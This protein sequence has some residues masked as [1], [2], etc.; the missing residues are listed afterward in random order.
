[1]DQ[2]STQ[3][4]FT[5][6]KNFQPEN[7]LKGAA[8]LAR[9]FGCA[10]T[11]IQT[12][13]SY[14]LVQGDSE[15]AK[16]DFKSKFFI[17]LDIIQQEGSL[18]KSISKIAVQN[19]ANMVLVYAPAEKGGLLGG[20]M[21]S[22][23]ASFECPVL[24]LNEKTQWVDPKNIVMP[25]DG[26]S[27][28]RQKLFRTAEWAKKYFSQV[29]ILGLAKPSNSEDKHYVHTYCVQAANKMVDM[30]VRH[31][32]EELE[33]KDSQTAG[34]VMERAKSLMEG[35]ISVVSNSDGMFKKSSF[36]ELCEISSFPIM[37]M[38]FQEV[39]GTGAV[40]Y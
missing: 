3:I 5:I 4:Y 15:K 34:I 19:K 6:Y 12:E 36:Q 23:I 9:K 25:F 39:V 17:E 30:Q 1:M 37:I 28:T 27:E 7:G 40:G 2:K 22:V 38:P 24:F 21:H 8:S 14:N 13:D 32:I 18:W 11:Y 20:G 10:A 31:K 35:W 26:R 16:R 33:A 29:L